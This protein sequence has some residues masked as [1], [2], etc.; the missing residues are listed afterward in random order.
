VQT[1]A[2]PI[3]LVELSGPFFAVPGDKRHGISLVEEEE[4]VGR[5]PPGDPQ[6]VGEPLGKV[7][8]ARCQLGCRR[9][10]GS[11]TAAHVKSGK[12]LR[13]SLNFSAARSFILASTMMS[14]WSRPRDR[15]S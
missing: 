13:S 3:F 12:A 14:R 9:R 15:T 11:V 1:C 10:Q 5:L 7:K 4:G 2:L 6:L 8:G